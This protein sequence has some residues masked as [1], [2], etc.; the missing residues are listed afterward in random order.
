M[1]GK[2]GT[3]N[4]ATLKSDAC[5]AARA[6]F[7]EMGVDAC[8]VCFW[9][10][11]RSPRWGDQALL[12]AHHIRPVSKGGSHDFENFVLV[13][14]NCHAIAHLL[15]PRFAP[16]DRLQF[17]LQLRPHTRLSPWQRKTL[18]RRDRQGET[19]GVA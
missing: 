6:R 17:I 3:A 4:A 19:A 2:A 13:C 18:N 10:A 8:Q 16:R 14:P 1:R 9:H 5:D 15:Y 11:P 7:A 12:H